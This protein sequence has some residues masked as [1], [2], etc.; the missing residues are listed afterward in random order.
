MGYDVSSLQDSEG[1]KYVKCTGLSPECYGRTSRWDEEKN[2]N[3]KAFGVCI[4]SS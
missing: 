3:L 2:R 1:M 4:G